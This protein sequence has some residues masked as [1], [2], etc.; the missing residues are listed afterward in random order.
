MFHAHRGG[1]LVLTGWREVAI[2]MPIDGRLLAEAL[3]TPM[4]LAKSSRLLG[5]IVTA[6][7]AERK[8]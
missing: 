4:F 5:C 7:A 6:G 2:G 1:P 8:G 3:Q